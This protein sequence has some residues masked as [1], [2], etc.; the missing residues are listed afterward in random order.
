MRC[1]NCDTRIPHGATSCPNCGVYAFDEP[2]QPPAPPRRV[3]WPLVAVVA[4]AL[5]AAGGWW[6]W[7][8]QQPKTK[9]KAPAK[10]LPVHVVRD[11]PGGNVQEAEAVRMLRRT[12]AARGVANECI[13]VM[14]HGKKG[15]AYEMTAVNSCDH[16]R[17]GNWR[18]EIG[19]GGQARVPVLH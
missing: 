17:L 12:L 7:S 15:N 9:A 11:R 19:E 1:T 6:W 8:T 16:T 13:A 18:V 4:I 2:P 10:P 3:W 14:S 5:L